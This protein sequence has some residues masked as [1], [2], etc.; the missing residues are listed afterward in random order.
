MIVEFK[1]NAKFNDSYK[2][3]SYDGIKADAYLLL[4][5]VG[6]KLGFLESKVFEH[7]LKNY[8]NYTN[9]FD[10][11]KDSLPDKLVDSFVS[12]ANNMGFTSGLIAGKSLLDILTIDPITGHRTW[13]SITRLININKDVR[14]EGGYGRFFDKRLRK[15]VK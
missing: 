5:N 2:S 7:H 4:R 1:E 15:L 9:L 11:V 10:A 12:N 13:G 3:L 14:D 6:V 8:S